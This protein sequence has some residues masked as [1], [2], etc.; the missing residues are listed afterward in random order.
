M[1]LQLEINKRLYMDETTRAKNAGFAALQKN[2]LTL[3]DHVL[4]HTE[5]ELARLSR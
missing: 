1:S 3:I 5:G 2:L 4:A